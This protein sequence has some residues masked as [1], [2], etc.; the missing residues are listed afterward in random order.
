LRTIV[1]TSLE[2]TVYLNAASVPRIIQTD[3]N[4][5]RNFSLVSLENGNVSDISLAWLDDKFTIVSQEII[6]RNRESPPKVGTGTSTSGINSPL[7]PQNT[8]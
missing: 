2:G 7:Q 3:T 4:K 6:Y 1:N 8:D 5:L